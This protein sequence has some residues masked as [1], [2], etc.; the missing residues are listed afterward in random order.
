MP[1]MQVVVYVK[2]RYLRYLKVSPN[3]KRTLQTDI[4]QDTSPPKIRRILFQ[5]VTDFGL[6]HLLYFHLF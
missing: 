1:I 3:Y 2:T 4:I 5:I 6:K